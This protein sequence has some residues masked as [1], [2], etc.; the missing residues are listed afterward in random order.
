MTSRP[1]TE[2]KKPARRTAGK[3]TPAASAKRG[4]A[5]SAAAPPSARRKPP[6]ERRTEIVQAASVLALTE[7]LESLTLRRVADALGVV[8]GLVNHYFRSVE[9]LVAEAFTAAAYGETSAVFRRRRAGRR[10]PSD[11]CRHSSPCW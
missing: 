5:L 7:G 6:E 2:G 10:P 9:D 1:L 8:P 3:R 4:P 11:A